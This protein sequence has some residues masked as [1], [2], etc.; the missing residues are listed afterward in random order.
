MA[1][2]NLKIAKLKVA[3][4]D[5]DWGRGGEGILGNRRPTY[6]NLYSFYLGCNLIYI[7]LGG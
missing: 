1:Q 3:S 4:E 7:F 2:N 5:V 6:V